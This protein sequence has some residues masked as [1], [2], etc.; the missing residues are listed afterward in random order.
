[1]AVSSLHTAAAIYRG[2]TK[3]FVKEEMLK[4]E[5]VNGSDSAVIETGPSG[6]KSHYH[7]NE[8]CHFSPQVTLAAAQFPW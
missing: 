8:L 6:E 5:A 1:M 2:K 7:Q 3:I 4:R